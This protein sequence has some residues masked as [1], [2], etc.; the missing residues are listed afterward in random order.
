M[1]RKI[2]L[3]LHNHH[4]KPLEVNH[5]LTLRDMATTILAT[6]ANFLFGVFYLTG[7]VLLAIPQIIVEV[8]RLMRRPGRIGGILR[9]HFNQSVNRRS[10]SV[11][12]LLTFIVNFGF[13]SLDALAQGQRM[14]SAVLRQSD[15]GL[16]NL[17]EGVT[18]LSVSDYTRAQTE[19]ALAMENF[20]NSQSV[21]T[22]TGV[23]LKAALKI[24]PQG[25]DAQKILTAVEIA[26][27]LGMNATTNLPLLKQIKIGP[28]GL[29]GT[30][31]PKQT[32]EQLVSFAET[33]HQQINQITELLSSINVASLPVEKQSVFLMAK[34]NLNTLRESSDTINAM[35]QIAKAFLLGRHQILLA[36]LNNNELR[37]GGGFLGTVG[38]ATIQDGTLAALDI[39]T[40]YDYDGQLKNYYEVPKPMLMANNR[41]F[42]RDTNWFAD[43]RDNALAMKRLFEQTSD[44]KPELVVA[45]TPDIII[46]ALKRT[47]PIDLPQ[48]QVTL[49]AENF[50]ETTQVATSL[51]YDKFLNQPKQV[52]ADFAPALL[53]KLGEQEDS[54]SFFLTL[55]FSQLTQKNLTIVAP[56]ESINRL[57]AQYHWSGEIAST[58]RDYLQIVQANLGGTK[59]DLELVRNLRLDVQIN[60]RGE[61]WHELSYTVQNPL[62]TMDRLEN[63]SFIRFLL[64]LGTEVVNAEGF[65]QVDPPEAPRDNPYQVDPTVESWNGAFSYNEQL[66]GF[67]GT[68]GGKSY[69]GNWLVLQGGETK[70]VKLKYKLPFRLSRIDKYSLLLQKQTGANINAHIK[71]DYPGYAVP[72]H[73]NKLTLSPAGAAELSTAVNSD[74]FISMVL[75]KP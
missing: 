54:L 27:N 19:F 1:K 40:V 17:R 30:E 36:F 34:A 2:R 63:K 33:S 68:E 59:T 64:P 41:W 21:I 22:H 52:L 14:K 51:Q 70:T 47:G 25:Q 49:S 50:V 69:Y 28:Q 6:G 5:R 74:I 3:Y 75:Q 38:L 56:D 20:R 16:A 26:T 12:L 13:M 7:L 15:D 71:L 31:N 4:Y 23:M 9:L 55:L 44:A 58:D 43:H 57:F 60:A 29:A 45:M 67:T 37:P 11:F 53:Q 32:L 61:I 8:G 18:A 10:V 42:L 62:P 73:N 35:A 66:H 39:R 24:I 72:W 48:H 65:D 46:E